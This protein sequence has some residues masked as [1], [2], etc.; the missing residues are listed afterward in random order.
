MEGGKGGGEEEENE[1]VTPDRR[2]VY[3][4]LQR[5]LEVRHA[6]RAAPEP[7]LLAEVVPAPPADA[8]PAAR[9]AHLQGHA[10][11]Y[12]EPAHLGADGRHDAGRLVAERQ[13]RAGAEVP[14]GELLVVGDVRAADAR[15]PHG[16]LQL[17][18]ARLLDDPG[19]LRVVGRYVRVS[20]ENSPRRVPP[21]LVRV[22]VSPPGSKGIWN[23]S[24]IADHAAHAGRRR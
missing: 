5:A 23:D 6:L 22:T 15:R 11:P 19:L 1:L 24:P 21:P 14:V 9:D 13:G 20:R 8:A 10:V 3:P 7:H 2:V 4:L 17:A 18:D 16:D 12:L